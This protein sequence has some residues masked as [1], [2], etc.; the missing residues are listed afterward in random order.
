MTKAA[1][2]KGFVIRHSSF[3]SMSAIPTPQVLRGLQLKELGRYAEAAQV[4]QEALAADP[5]DAFALHQLAGCQ[6]QMPERR[7]DALQTI[8]QAIALEP[9]EAEHHVLQSFI[10]C[11]LDRPKEALASARAAL[12]LDPH[13]SAAFSA[14]AQAH[15]QSEQWAQ[16]ERAARQ[17]LELEADSTIAAN[18]LA[19]ALRLQNKLEENAGHL[20]AMLA[21]D[22]DDAYTHAN[23]GWAALQR[24]DRPGAEGHFREALRLDPDMEF[25]REGL[26][27]SFRAR[28]PFY[29]AYLRYCFFMQRLSSGSRWALIIGL[30]VAAQFGK[31][32]Q[33]GLG[34]AIVILYFVFVLWV[35][36]ARPVGN[37]F[38][39]LDRFARYALRPRE[40]IEALV[41][42]GG[43]L[44]GLVIVAASLAPALHRLDT[45]GIGLIAAAFPLSM[46][47]TNGSRSGT[48]L[49]G[50]I[51][52]ITLLSAIVLTLPVRL[53]TIATPFFGVS[54]AGCL[55]STW[56]GNVSALRK[57][58]P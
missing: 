52:A 56:L 26:L 44:A 25:A 13:S 32:L 38:L 28:S 39:C 2:T 45:L 58:L 21:R 15:L 47:F 55:L 19:Q 6:F 9:N 16:A 23:A 50:A 20:A 37:L 41:V 46:T 31:H 10:L 40:K 49:F 54:C 53:E 57:P 8:R 43:M 35:W 4:F 18:Q 29:S 36:V 11:V 33:G 51:G 17:A 48:L 12:S 3:P 34:L 30:Y 1:R 27:N 24:G 14:E 42:G 7:R 22:P 5:N